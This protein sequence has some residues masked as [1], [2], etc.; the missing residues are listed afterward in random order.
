MD[1]I[2]LRELRV[3]TVIGVWEWERRIRQTL[4]LDIELGTDTR[5][6]GDTDDLAHTVDYKA[7]SDRIMAF[8]RDSDFQ[9]IE[10]LGE[11]ICTL[12][13]KEFKLPWMRLKM[14][15]Q[16]VVPGVKE[17]GIIIERGQRDG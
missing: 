7:V 15:K 4:V 3:D 16:G 1:I 6:A 5:A 2:F 12:V 8:C 13:L 11:G 17:V 9:L 10:A 14:T